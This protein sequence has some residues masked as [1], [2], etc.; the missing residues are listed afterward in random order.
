MSGT[1]EKLPEVCFPLGDH[2]VKNC[3][4]K[5]LMPKAIRQRDWQCQTRIPRSLHLRIAC[6]DCCRASCRYSRRRLAHCRR[7]SRIDQCRR[8]ERTRLCHHCRFRS[9]ETVFRTEPCDRDHPGDPKFLKQNSTKPFRTMSDRV[10]LWYSFE[11]GHWFVR[12]APEYST[13]RR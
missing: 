4:R 8:E 2:V 1:E 3:K 12:Q 6:Q 7:T 5:L 13:D 11:S 10:I 9:D